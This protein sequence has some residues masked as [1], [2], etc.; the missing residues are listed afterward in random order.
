MVTKERPW[1]PEVWLWTPGDG[2]WT[3]EAGLPARDVGLVLSTEEYAPAD[4]YDAW[5]NTVFHDF[6]ASIPNPEQ[7]VDFRADVQGIVTPTGTLFRYQSDPVSGRRSPASAHAATHDDMAIGLVLEG[8]RQHETV[9]GGTLL[10]RSL[11]F[12]VYDPTRPSRVTWPERHSAIA[13]TMRRAALVEAFNGD[14]PV[15]AI[16]VDT[17]QRSSLSPFLVS[18]LRLLSWK[19]DKLSVME[20]A[21]LF[22][23]V[24][25][26]LL[27]VIRSAVQGQGAGAAPLARQTL[28]AAAGRYIDAHLTDSDLDADKIA[29]GVG[30]SRAT[31]YRCF[32]DRGLTVAGAVRIAR[33]RK[34]CQLL[35]NEP[36][37]I[38]I[39]TLA[40]K[41]GFMDL[42]TFNRQF[43]EM[44]GM[45][46]GAF[47]RSHSRN[48][49]TV[50]AQ[51]AKK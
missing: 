17:L 23:N 26:L 13:V 9:D 28:N 30:C 43:S 25:D 32:A 16:I 24:A 42:R 41:T 37:R 35:Q 44:F 38:P 14:I 22:G 10:A 15:E 12:F 39:A 2:L 49:L 46:A 51:A 21:L 4:R 5:R 48:M 20:K 8:S 11:E 45:T 29:R 3:P 1:P 34:M 7:R 18:Q 33:L 40:L 27:G 31:L 19:L 6:D 36:S 47:R 50:F